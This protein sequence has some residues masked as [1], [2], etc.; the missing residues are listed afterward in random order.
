MT[1][2]RDDHEFVVVSPFARTGLTCTPDR[3]DRIRRLAEPW[4]TV[5]PGT[6][7]PGEW[8]VLTGTEPTAAARPEVVAASG[9]VPVRYAVDEAARLLFHLLPDGED[10]RVQSALRATRAI[11]RSAASRAGDLFLHAGLLE[12]NGTGILLAGGSRAGKTTFIMTTVLGGTG[13]MISN[14]DSSLYASAD[15]SVTG[16]GWPRSVSVRLDT[17]D[18]LFGRDRATELLAGLSHPA[19]AT[20]P[21]LRESGVEPHGT[22]L[23]Y[24]WEYARLLGTEI[25][26]RA[27]VGAVV[28]LGLADDDE[29]SHLAEVPLPERAALLDRQLLA[30]PNKHL[31]IFGHEPA[32]GTTDRARLALKS[33]PTYRFRYRFREVRQEVDRLTSFLSTR[34]SVTS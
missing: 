1:A 17:L 12:V 31:N 16:T 10:W 34:P 28:H 18:V 13:R 14:D 32:A 30:L 33:L 2:A 7:A 29:E 23:F 4:L 15:G 8:R 9:E 24:P 11:H 20:L 22:A 5:Q 26:K 6:A 21:G 19:N 27:G 3:A 25:G